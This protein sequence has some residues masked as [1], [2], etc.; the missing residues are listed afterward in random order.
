MLQQL[1]PSEDQITMALA[2]WLEILKPDCLWT[3]IANQM[4]M[5]GV[6]RKAASIIGHQLKRMGKKKGPADFMFVGCP[7][8]PLWFYEIKRK[9]GSMKKEQKEW[10]TFCGSRGVPYIYQKADNWEQHARLIQIK[11]KEFGAL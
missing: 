9:D 4:P 1:R 11:L 5:S 8:I 6:D 7:G 10:L 2:R 3:H